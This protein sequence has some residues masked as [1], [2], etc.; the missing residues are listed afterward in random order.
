MA[1]IKL[2]ENFADHPKFEGVSD[3]A[4]RIWVVAISYA[5]RLRTDGLIPRNRVGK[6]PANTRYPIKCAEELVDAGLWHVVG[7]TCE[8]EFCPCSFHS[9]DGS[10]R[11]PNGSGHSPGR[12]PTAPVRLDD[13]STAALCGSAE[14][15]ARGFI[16]HDYWEYQPSRAELDEK[17]AKKAEAGR[18]GGQAK[19]KQGASSQDKPVPSRPVPSR[20]DPKREIGKPDRF[21]TLTE[22]EAAGFWRY[23]SITGSARAGIGQLLPITAEELAAAT[24]TPGNS[25]GYAAKVIASYREQANAP[26]PP[27]AGNGSRRPNRPPTRAELAAIVFDDDEDETEDCPI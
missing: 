17:S 27:P 7:D 25:W 5:N 9:P 1:W 2:E 26:T 18:K 3:S 23:N 19:P 6:L 10:G 15:P 21:S 4:F 11:P 20:P 24:S 13:G 22:L 16:I 14:S 12:L 8:S